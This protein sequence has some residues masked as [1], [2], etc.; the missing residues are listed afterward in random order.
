MTPSRERWRANNQPWRNS[1]LQKLLRGGLQPS[2]SIAKD[3]P[4]L[5]TPQNTL[6]LPPNRKRPSNS[7]NYKV[8]LC[9]Y[10]YQGE[11]WSIEIQALSYKDAEDRMKVISKGEIIGKLVL[12]IPVLPKKNLVEIIKSW[13]P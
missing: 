2:I 4:D 13:L 10:I 11:K 7:N 1:F 8:Y 6:D 5:C 12:R 9:D 3:R